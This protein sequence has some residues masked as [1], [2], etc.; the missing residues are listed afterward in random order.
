M[1]LEQAAGLAAQNELQLWMTNNTRLGIPISFSA[2]T[3]HSAV[4]GGS[5]DV[6]GNGGG[7]VMF[8]M[9]CLQGATWNVRLVEQV[10]DSARARERERERES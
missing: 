6:D 3:L 2:E 1:L 10:N 5:K 8:P 9:P 7:S 4:G